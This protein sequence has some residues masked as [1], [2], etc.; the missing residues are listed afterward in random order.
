[1][2]LFLEV[3][4]YV[5][6]FASGYY[7]GRFMEMRSRIVLLPTPMSLHEARMKLTPEQQEQLRT[8][9]L[10]AVTKLKET[11]ERDKDDIR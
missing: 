3:F 2:E 5:A 1:M 8:D 9:L 6:V 11:L 4:T 7:F 10:T